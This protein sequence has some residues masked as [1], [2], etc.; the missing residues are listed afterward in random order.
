MRIRSTMTGLVAAGVL[1]TSAL[2]AC[3]SSPDSSTNSEG[4]GS[5]VSADTEATLTIWYYFDPTAEPTMDKLAEQFHEKYPNVKLEYLF[6]DFANMRNKVLT[7]ATAQ[8]GPD[9]LLFDPLDTSS[10]VEAGALAP[11]GD[12]WS[13]FDGQ[14]EFADFALTSVDDELYAVQSYVNTTALWYNADILKEIG[15]EPPTNIDEFGD[16]MAKAKDAGY[17][18]VALCG[19]PTNECETQGIAWLMGGG[20]NYDSLD[21]EEATSVLERFSDWASEGYF[22]K[23]VVSA[24]HPTASQQFAS[25]KFAFGQMGNWDLSVVGDGLDF[26]WGVVPLPGAQVAP[27]GEAE[28]IGAFSDNQRLA[29]EYLTSTFWSKEGQV[30]FNNGR[31]SIPIRPDAAADETVAATPHIDA[32]LTEIENAGKRSPVTSGDLQEATQTM[33]QIWSNVLG[34]TTSAAAAQEEMVSRISPLFD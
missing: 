27:G 18:G 31:G 2:T 33:G 23:E 1:L 20:A 22:S 34:G 4:L 32:W 9:V 12:E 8:D 28:A 24:D 25:G 6:V 26:E 14:D 29:W 21:S 30:I 3:G 7:A 19:K 13:E 16:A 11:L 10:L 15:V 5:E 17:S